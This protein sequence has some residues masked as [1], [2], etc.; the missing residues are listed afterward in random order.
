MHQ[1]SH[2]GCESIIGPSLCFF[3][4]DNRKG[5]ALARATSW[6]DA[7][8][9]PTLLVFYGGEWMGGDQPN[10]LVASSPQRDASFPP[11]I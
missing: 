2:A 1:A 5:E 6:Q 4:V 3:T 10:P 9:A 7:G 11:G 8:G